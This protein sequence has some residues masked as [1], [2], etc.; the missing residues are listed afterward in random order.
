MNYTKTQSE[1][2]SEI[3]KNEGGRGVKFDEMEGTPY[4]GVLTC[5][6]YGFILLR[7]QFLLDKSKM[8]SCKLL[9]DIYRREGY[10]KQLKNT[11]IIRKTE[12]R[13]KTFSVI[14]LETE[15][16]KIVWLNEK[17]VKKFGKP[18]ELTFW[19]ENEKTV[20]FVY[21]GNI[22]VGVIMPINRNAK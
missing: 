8:E 11:G 1:I 19:S 15:N 9:S 5:S 6:Y 16:G 20:V 14:E 3:Y 21:E 2:I 4:V 22:L 13:K 7:N 18:E 12:I 17:Y 10:V